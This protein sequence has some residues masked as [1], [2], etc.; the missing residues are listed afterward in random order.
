[1]LA[2]RRRLQPIDSS[3]DQ[4]AAAKSPTGTLQNLGISRNDRT[5]SQSDTEPTQ[6]TRRRTAPQPRR[7]T[8]PH[9]P[10][11]SRRGEERSGGRAGGRGAERRSACGRNA[12]WRRRRRRAGSSRPRRGSRPPSPCSPPSPPPPAR[13]PPLQHHSLRST[14][15]GGG[16]SAH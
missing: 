1:V 6:S 5:T 8:G 11:E 2:A 13:L 15:P 10:R 12:P 4:Y 16:A 9:P 3:L 14:H 7:S